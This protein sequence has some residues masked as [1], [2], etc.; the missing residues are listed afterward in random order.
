MFR[1][2]G[3]PPPPPRRPYPSP[4]HQFRHPFPPAPAPAIPF[5]PA[6]A[7][8]K[9][10]RAGPASR[11][12]KTHA[13]HAVPCAPP[14]R[15][16]AANVDISA[17]LQSLRPR[18]PN[19]PPDCVLRQPA[20]GGCRRALWSE[21]G[22]A[23]HW[24]LPSLPPPPRASPAPLPQPVPRGMLQGTLRQ[25][26]RARGPPGRRRRFPAAPSRPV[27]AWC[28]GATGGRAAGVG[29]SQKHIFKHWGPTRT[30][31]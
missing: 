14:P 2:S 22:G 21:G 30:R 13:V 26:P 28:Q 15:A 1:A 17:Q 10:P 20:A 31:S 24:Q 4:K 27:G 8:A 9:P 6:P 25:A 11:L 7:P 23:A 19:C 18:I 16:S 12:R 29:A 3:L 5:P